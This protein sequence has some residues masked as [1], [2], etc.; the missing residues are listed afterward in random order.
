MVIKLS[1]TKIS[2]IICI[3]VTVIMVITSIGF[4]IIKIILSS[5]IRSGKS[6]FD[7]ESLLSF[8]VAVKHG[9]IVAW[10]VTKTFLPDIVTIGVSIA[11]CVGYIIRNKN[12]VDEF[13]EE[14]IENMKVSGVRSPS[15]WIGVYIFVTALAGIISPSIIAFTFSGNS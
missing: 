10:D 6:S 13:D 8:G 2:N 5:L 15:F 9:D 1:S 3:A 4:F 7:A 11:L 12:S 14:N